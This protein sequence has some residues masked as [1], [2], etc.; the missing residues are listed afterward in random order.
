MYKNKT[1]YDLELVLLSQQSMLKQTRVVSA[2]FAVVILALGVVSLCFN[3]ITTGI[4]LL[5]AGTLVVILF[6][7]LS[8]WFL[9]LTMQ[10]NLKD[11]SV[12]VEYMFSNNLTIT[13]YV[14]GQTITQS[15]DY[16][17]MF[18]IVEQE[19]CLIIC[20]SKNDALIMRKDDKFLEYKNFIQDKMQDRYIV[21]Q[22]KTKRKNKGKQ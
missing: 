3:K 16:N 14:D 13:S 12:V 2:L 18:Q 1:V 10:K 9:K 11:R 5:I 7:F 6:V 20:P 19:S 8:G 4:C 21:E 22:A 17:N 15:F